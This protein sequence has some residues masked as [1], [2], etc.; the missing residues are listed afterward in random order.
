M[1]KKALNILSDVM[2][3]PPAPVEKNPD[4]FNHA[5]WMCGWDTEDIIEGSQQGARKCP[6]CGANLDQ[7]F[8]INTAPDELMLP[9]PKQFA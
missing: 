5:C 3:G 2:A 9:N 4:S 6:R 1:L 8:A 7:P